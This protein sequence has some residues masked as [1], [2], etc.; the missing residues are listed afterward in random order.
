MKK[1]FFGLHMPK[2]AG[3]S[4]LSE[5]KR[6]YG[7]NLYQS[8]SLITNFRENKA[9]ITDNYDKLDY[10]GYFGH[11]FCDELLKLIG[12]DI[13]LFTFLREPLDRA[14]SHYK[15]INRMNAA[16]GLPK[17]KFEDFINT[18]P[19][20]TKF[21]VTR[22]PGLIDVKD[23]DSPNWVK[24]T[25]VLKKFN[26]VGDSNNISSFQDVFLKEFGK[27]ICLNEVKNKAPIEGNE[28]SYQVREAAFKALYE[29]ILLYQWYKKF[30]KNARELSTESGIESFLETPF[31]KNR[32]FEFHA[33]S[34]IQEFKAN[35]E[36]GILGSYGFRSAEFS[37]KLSEKLIRIEYNA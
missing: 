8:T 14:L 1:V 33:N 23:E 28:F 27:N 20:I 35:N 12:D 31:N 30:W 7:N 37:K 25:S 19:S 13:F 22:F 34:L 3:T 9:D 11:H 15:Y 21:I 32:F 26:Y 29:D 18:L 4:V 17:V 5:L 2:C 24:A 10:S 6:C 36:L 16:V